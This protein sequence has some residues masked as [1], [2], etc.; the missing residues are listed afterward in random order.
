MSATVVAAVAAAASAV[1]FMSPAVSAW[2]C[3]RDVSPLASLL[4]RGQSLIGDAAQQC[5]QFGFILPAEIAFLVEP[6]D[7]L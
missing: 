3:A 1:A 7:Q 4:F 2:L 6:I 5:F